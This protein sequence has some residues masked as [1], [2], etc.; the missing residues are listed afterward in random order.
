MPPDGGVIVTMVAGT[1]SALADGV[2]PSRAHASTKPM[3]ITDTFVMLNNPKTG[4]TFARTVLKE[5]HATYRRVQFWK[6][7]VSFGRVRAPLFKELYLPDLTF[8]GSLLKESSQ[9]GAYSQIPDEYRDRE[10]VSV[11]RNPYTLFISHYQFR[12]WA[13]HPPFPPAFLAEKFPQFPD[14][15]IDDFVDFSRLRVA[16]EPLGERLTELGVGS[17]SRFFIKMFYREPASIFRHL[18]RQMIDSGRLLE[19]LPT[20]TFLR[21]EHLT[22]DLSHFLRRHGYSERELQHV[23]EHEKVNLTK[24]RVADPTALLTPKVLSHIQTNELL[25]LRLLESVGIKYYPPQELSVDGYDFEA[26]V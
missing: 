13:T 4:S 23:A 2:P 17:M 19:L 25:L 26:R 16:H 5:I 15:S 14:L 21:Q 9:H 11:V 18:D 1:E 3:I 12:W 20:I 24:D 10:V 8:D 6:R 7:V 22:D